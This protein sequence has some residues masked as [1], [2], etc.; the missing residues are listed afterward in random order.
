MQQHI[1]RGRES[2]LSAVLGL[3]IVCYAA[4]RVTTA[5]TLTVG[6]SGCDFTTIQAAIDDAATSDGDT[7][8]VEDAVHTEQ[9]IA[10][11]K[12]VTIQGY[13][14]DSTIVQAH[15][16][17]GSAT[18]RV[19]TVSGGGTI[20]FK[21]MTIRH[22]KQ[23]IWGG[24]AIR[25]NAS[26]TVL[27]CRLIRNDVSAAYGGAVYVDGSSYTLTIE[28]TTI[29]E[30]TAERGAAIMSWGD[31]V[32][33]GS[34][35]SANS[36]SDYGGAIYFEVHEF[37]THTLS[38][39]NSTISG[40]TSTRYGGGLFT[41]S[42]MGTPIVNLTNVTITDN[43]S[44]NDD[45]GNENGGGLYRV[46]GTVNIKNSLIANN[47]RG[48][49]TS[50][51]DDIGGTV[52]SQDYNLIGTTAGA[53]ITGTT[54]NNITGQDSLLDV[55]ADNG[56]P[57]LTHALQAGS[58]ARDQIPNGVNG[59]GT[60][61]LDIDQ[62]GETRPALGDGDMGAYEAQTGLPTVTT[63]AV[64]EV[65][66]TTANSGGNVTADGGGSVTARGVCWSTSADP[67][68]V[69][70]KTTDGTGTGVFVSSI[71]DL[72]PDTTYHVRA[73]ATNGTGTGLTAADVEFTTG[74]SVTASGGSAA[75]HRWRRVTRLWIPLLR[76]RPRNITN[77]MVSIT[78]NFASGDVLA[79]T[80]PRCRAASGRPTAAR[81]VHPVVQRHRQCG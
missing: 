25:A 39:T 35:L 70:S 47:Y 3:A 65:T 71:T 55:L 36:T 23:T 57:T 18:D 26:V 43:H 72:S 69:D 28:D 20:T 9:G 32:I 53:T 56:G 58:P 79:Y 78:G 31:V 63:T 22:G 81:P 27:R 1:L 66:T 61:P 52:N 2:V 51:A 24:S 68:T 73:Y 17:R 80:R 46:A 34:T 40:N 41:T 38:I 60:D 19:F 10:V 13:G 7:I 16:V 42:A 11:D 74:I 77:F 48:S 15:A 21:D 64:S 6:A 12:A 59:M 50:T 75:I 49:G 30:N 8:S 14:V 45:S 67:S 37:E 44:D 5:A 29:T 54:T 62:R 76:S 33:N 4:P